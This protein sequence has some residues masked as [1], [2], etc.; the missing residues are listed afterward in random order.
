[1]S[2]TLNEVLTEPVSGLAYRI[3][4]APAASAQ[5]P[6]LLLLHGVGS[7][8]TGFIE[9]A[10]QMDPRL[11]VVLLRGPLVMAPGR[12]GWFQVRFTPSGPVIDA[13]Q[14]ERSRA[15]LLEFIGRLPD[16]HGV[17]PARIW[18]AGFSQG[19]I[20]SASVGLTAPASVAGFGVLSGRIL[21]E[22]LP[23]VQHGPAL[24]RLEAFVSHG[25]HDQTLG[26]HFAQ[27]SRELLTG[28]GVPLA[29]SEY[30]AGHALDGAMIA[31]FQR[32][33]GRQLDMGSA[34][35]GAA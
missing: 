32:W 21:A 11:T 4:P 17:D 35:G 9:L 2:D 19:G 30:A 24:A 10:R 15:L 18:I 25:V 29:Y 6:C 13:A 27:Q 7:N 23:Q 28:L 12:F 8:E 22:V 20:M 33:L 31:D 3:R 16:D 5:A 34:V 26:L 14:A 1:M